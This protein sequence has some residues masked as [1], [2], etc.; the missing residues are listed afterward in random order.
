MMRSRW[1]R[2][3]A[4]LLPDDDVGAFVT[5]KRGS[6]FML[7]CEATPNYPREIVARG[8]SNCR[9]HQELNPRISGRRT[10]HSFQAARSPPTPMSE[11]MTPAQGLSDGHLR[12]LGRVAVN[13]QAVESGL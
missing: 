3:I 8:L 7:I 13:F 11:P 2:N 12:A 4:T 1:V 10:S 9:S 5:R 6:T